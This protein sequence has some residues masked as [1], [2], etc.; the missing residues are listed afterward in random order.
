[1][2]SVAR[3]EEYAEFSEDHVDVAAA[4]CFVCVGS[5]ALR[6]YGLQNPLCVE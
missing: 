1:M 4:G 2:G 3:D 6:S 5:S